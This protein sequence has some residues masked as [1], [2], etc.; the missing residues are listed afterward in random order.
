M[1]YPEISVIIPTYNNGN[2]IYR[3]IRSVLNQDVFALNGCTVELIVINDAS[4]SSYTSYLK[5]LIVDYPRIKLLH[6]AIRLGPAAARNYGIREAKGSLISFLDADDE[7]PLNKFSL[8]LPFFKNSKI[9]VTGGKIKYMVQDGLPQSAIQFEDEENRLTHVHLGAL[10]LRRTIFE[11]HFYFDE[12]LEFSEDMDWWLRLRENDI[13]IVIIEATTLI[14]HVH[15][16]NMTI[17]KNIQELQ[18]LKILHNS[19][20]RRKNSGEIQGL[21]QIRDFRTEQDPLISIVLPL[22]NG[23]TLIKKAIDSVLAQT[24]TNWELC[25]IDDGSTDGGADYIAKNYPAIRIIPQQNSGVAAARNKGI[26]VSGGHIMAFLDQDDEWMPSKLSEQWAVLKGDPYCTFVTCNQCFAC[27]DGTELPAHFGD[28]LDEEHRSFVPSSLLIRKHALLSINGFDVT[29][30][31]SS[32]VDLIRRLRRGNFR[33]AN[34]ESLLLRKWYHGNNASFDMKKSC[35]ELL[36]IL[37]KQVH[38]L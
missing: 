27:Y 38:G 26:E 36:G 29:L 25:I 24:Y 5:Q 19:L 13:G 22:Y 35:S 1:N 31:L 18:V 10:L 16:Q 17:N 37:H 28:K 7:W 8:L 14:Y 12:S 2:E 20:Q 4:E 23:K 3:A 32:D 15:G 34:V 6:H 33:E 21:P 9:E 11:K 30:E